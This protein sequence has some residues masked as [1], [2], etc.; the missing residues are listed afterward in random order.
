M[1]FP[2]LVVLVSFRCDLLLLC[3]VILLLCVVLLLYAVMLL[4][5]FEFLVQCICSL[6]GGS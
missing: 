3:A 6:F 4:S 5:S 2:P 1:L